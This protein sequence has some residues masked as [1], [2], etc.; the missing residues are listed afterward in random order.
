METVTPERCVSYRSPHTLPIALLSLPVEGVSL[1]QLSGDRTA[2]SFHLK[3]K[4]KTAL[5]V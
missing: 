5:L 3:H 1:L 4:I 2:M